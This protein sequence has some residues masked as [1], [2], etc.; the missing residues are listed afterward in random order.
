MR[1]SIQNLRGERLKKLL[2]EVS[3]KFC[4]RYL[5]VVRPSL[6][7]SQ[8][9]HTFLARLAPSILSRRQVSEWPGTQL[10]DGELADVYEGELSHHATKTFA[11]S[12]GSLLDFQQPALPEDLSLLREDG[13]PWLITCAHESDIYLELSEQELTEIQKNF[14]LDGVKLKLWYTY[15][16]EAVFI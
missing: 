1:V 11:A 2:V 5:L 15:S 14:Q 16:G 13:S 10:L 6:G 8:T 12:V 3:P 9:L 7:T 4:R